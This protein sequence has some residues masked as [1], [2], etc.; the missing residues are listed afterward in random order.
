[1]FEG[2]RIY[3]FGNISS[4][5]KEEMKK[6]LA[7]GGAEILTNLP[8]NSQS[9]KTIVVCDSNYVEELDDS[10]VAPIKKSGLKVVDYG[11]VLDSISH[12]VIL[13]MTEYVAE[14]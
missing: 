11:W 7:L 4:P 8:R 2:Y 3:L 9:G 5:N 12:Y 14:I 13:P 6:L 1:M 10:D